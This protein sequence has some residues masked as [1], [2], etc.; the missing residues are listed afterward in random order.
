MVGEGIETCLAAMQAAHLG[1]WAALSTGGLRTLELPP[2]VR[3][4]TILADGDEPG[5]K[6]AEDAAKR[7]SRERRRVRIARSPAGTDF[8]DLLKGRRPSREAKG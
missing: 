5:A 6:A 3:D 2:N 1:A 8:N 7:W 4:V